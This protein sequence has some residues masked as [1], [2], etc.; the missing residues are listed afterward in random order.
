MAHCRAQSGAAG[1]NC[2]SAGIWRIGPKIAQNLVMPS[3]RATGNNE[4]DEDRVKMK[5]ARSMIIVAML[6]I[7]MCCR[8][9]WGVAATEQDGVSPTLAAISAARGFVNLELGHFARTHTLLRFHLN[10]SPSVSPASWKK[11][12]QFFKQ[13]HVGW[14]CKLMI[15]S[16]NHSGANPDA[17]EFPADSGSS[18]FTNPRQH[19]PWNSSNLRMC[20]C[21]CVFV[22]VFVCSVFLC[23]VCLCRYVVLS[24]L[25]IHN[26]KVCCN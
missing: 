8:G 3:P 12:G 24:V 11:L 18:D 17:E 1:V 16:F 25:K 21:V 9:Q 7:R 4:E 23:L 5:E 13:I 19:K 2:R 22:C 6:M 14:K 10:S 15:W 20:G 26:S